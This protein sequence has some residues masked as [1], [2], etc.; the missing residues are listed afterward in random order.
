[1]NKVILILLVS[2][3]SI[4]FAKEIDMKVVKQLAKKDVNTILEHTHME[5]FAL[6]DYWKHVHGRNRP[7]VVFFYANKH[8]PSQR[9]ATLLKYIVPLYS[10]KL[11]FASM[12]VSE[13][14][15]PNKEQARILET[16]YSLDQTPGIL[17]YDN[18]NNEMVLEDEDYIDAD[19]KEFRTPSMFF[20][21]RY[22]IG[23][24]KELDALLAD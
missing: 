19:F 24:R 2:I 12:Q 1:M 23:V 4:V 17:F 6:E 8:K 7:L 5:H 10:H 11:A 15:I 13:N 22:Y 16:N 3:V 18:V 20:W 14:G 21:K 9:L